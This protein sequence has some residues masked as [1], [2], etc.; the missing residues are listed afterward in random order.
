[1]STAAQIHAN[2]TNA[3]LST[4]P[5]T[6]GKAAVAQNNFRRGLPSHFSV[7]PSENLRNTLPC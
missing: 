6:E 5:K 7:L 1:M 4:G 2:R 3:Q